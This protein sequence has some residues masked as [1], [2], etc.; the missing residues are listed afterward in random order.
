MIF[1]TLLAQA[2]PATADDQVGDL[3]IVTVMGALVVIPTIFLVIIVL[4]GR[5]KDEDGV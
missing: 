4:L 1:T 5:S 2:Q 3:M